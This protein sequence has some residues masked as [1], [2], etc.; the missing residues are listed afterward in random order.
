MK[1]IRIYAKKGLLLLRRYALG[2]VHFF[3]RYPPYQA[4]LMDLRGME[5]NRRTAQVYLQLKNSG[6]Q[7]CFR[8]SPK[9]YVDTVYDGMHDYQRT[10][11]DSLRLDN[12]R[13]KYA[14][15]FC[16]ESRASEYP[17]AIV[18]NDD[19]ASFSKRV[20]RAFY[21]PILFHPASQQRNAE[22]LLPLYDGKRKIGVVFIGNNAD[23][24]I[25]HRDILRDRYG[26]QTRTEVLS[27]L[28]EH[29][30]DRIY[31][32]ESRDELMRQLSKN[33][34]GLE[35][36]IVIVDRFRLET[37]D[38]LT[39]LNQSSFQIWTA[40]YIQ[41]YCHNQCEGLACGAIPVYNRNICYPLPDFAA[42]Y[43]YTDLDDLGE[44]IRKIGAID[45][46]SKETEE[47]N[48]AIRQAFLDHLSTEAFRR[49]METFVSSDLS[50]ETY[51]HCSRE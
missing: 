9:Q 25:N 14:A 30:F 36:K 32:P 16:A 45:I 24:Y 40:G 12:H 4:Y 43:S 18:F 37:A 38:Y 34:S 48:R 22:S 3:R 51:Y 49:K 17:K 28:T 50:R 1:R 33:P 2:F 20:D 7:V 46:Q 21:F 10:F 26:L 41:P 47:M 15:V 29:Y 23:S 44:I 8:L 31:R 11:F 5:I 6:K 39:V 35:D 27:Y 13:T 19:T 42:D